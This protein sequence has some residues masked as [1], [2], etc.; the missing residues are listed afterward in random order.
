MSGMKVR[1]KPD[2]AVAVGGV[3]LV[4]GNEVAEVEPAP[5]GRYKL[6]VPQGDMAGETMYVEEDL[7]DVLSE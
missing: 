2:A 7:F 6:V 3:M 1:F 4:L 5:D